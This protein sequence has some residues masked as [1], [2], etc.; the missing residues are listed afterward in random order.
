V[1]LVPKQKKTLAELVAVEEALTLDQGATAGV[2]IVLH[3][4]AKGI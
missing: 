1:R 3:S 2:V 4:I